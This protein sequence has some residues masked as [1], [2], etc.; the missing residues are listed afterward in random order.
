[1]AEIMRLYNTFLAPASDTLLDLG[2]STA[3][4]N[5]FYV[6]GTNS[7]SVVSASSVNV[8]ILTVNSSFMVGAS[9]TG[10]TI[11]SATIT[12]LTATS[13]T[14]TSFRFTKSVGSSLVL[15]NSAN[16]SLNMSILTHNA[17]SF[18]SG[19]VYLFSSSN[20]VYIAIG[21]RGATY[22]VAMDT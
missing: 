18:T 7:A 13:D 20:R 4:W 15:S 17:A 6:K 8:T 11:N 19:D 10:M 14:T 22:F 3:R 12:V 1:M 5:N 16:S 21:S 9:A 2:A